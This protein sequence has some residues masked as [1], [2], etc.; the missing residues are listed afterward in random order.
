MCKNTLLAV[1]STPNPMKKLLFIVMLLLSETLSA[2][3]VFRMPVVRIQPNGDT[4]HLFLTG[5]E[6]YHR[7]HDSADF[8]IVQHP[9]TGY[10]VYADIARQDAEHWD[11]IATDYRVG[12]V[13]PQSVGLQPSVGIDR[14]SWLKCQQRYQV[15]EWAAVPRPKTSG[16]NHGTL[17][18]I[19]IFIRFADDDEIA[20]PFDTILDGLIE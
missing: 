16:R 5:D 9:Q 17:N 7:L 19:V 18:N 12:S 11:V 6:Y 2:V 4:L 20:T 8:T 14:T 1:F 3:P 13:N 15:P 10:W